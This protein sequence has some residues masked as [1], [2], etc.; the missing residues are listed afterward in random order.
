MTINLNTQDTQS[1]K[2]LGLMEQA[3]KAAYTKPVDIVDTTTAIAFVAGNI[4][5]QQAIDEFLRIGYSIDEII[6]Y[7]TSLIK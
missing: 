2:L 5:P 7:A 4:T 3:Q 1:D 6:A